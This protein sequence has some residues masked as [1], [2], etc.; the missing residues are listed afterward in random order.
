VACG[1]DV[2]FAGS[3]V[4]V[5]VSANSVRF[6][7]NV[8]RKVR[9]LWAVHAAPSGV[10]REVAALPPPVQCYLQIAIG[11]SETSVATVRVRRA[12]T[13]RTAPDQPWLAIRGRQFFNADPPGF[14]WWG[15]VRVAPGLWIEARDESVQGAGGMLVKAGASW[16]LADAS[17][18]RSTRARC[19][20][21]SAR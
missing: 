4:G 7:R 13:F 12:G 18:R 5:V 6:Q 9:T 19:C 10:T 1:L 14:V 20:G 3:A 16:T 21:C 11:R 15:R 17:G 2:V 8:A